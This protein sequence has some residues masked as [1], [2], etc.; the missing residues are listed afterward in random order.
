MTEKSVTENICVI[1]GSGFIGSRLCSILKRND[2]AFTIFDQN[3]SPFFSEHVQRGQIEKY[4]E[5]QAGINRVDTL[6]HLAA[7][8]RDDV[9]PKSLYDLVNVEG[10]KNVCALAEDKGINRII[11]TSSVAVYGFAPENTDETGEIN[12]FNDYGRTKWE[13]E[14][15]LREW[16]EKDP[17]K[18]TLV[19]VRP[20]VVFG[21]QNRGNVYNLL[22]LIASGFFV[23]IGKGRNVK[24]MAYVENVAAFLEHCA[25][26]SGGYHLYNYIDK[27]DLDMNTLVGIVRSKLGKGS[28]VGLRIPYPVGMLGGLFFDILSRI[29]G[30]TFP[31]SRIRV[32]KFCSTT[33]FDT[34][35]HETGFKAK[36]SLQEGLERTVN[37]EFLEKHEDEHIF[38]SE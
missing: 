35:A 9:R 4:D 11:F 27:P 26:L 8:H 3:D 2:C 13:A 15:V 31:V 6:I 10:T 14:K 5:L 30:K 34:S 24:S 29:S 18:R 20:T 21:E 28:G 17:E 12:Y 37:Y 38:Y 1:G 23:M 22:R 7:V 19:I 16:H 32:K 25:H 33:Q 36:V